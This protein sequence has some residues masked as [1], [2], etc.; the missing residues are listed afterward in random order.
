[1]QFGKGEFLIQ[2]EPKAK[3]YYLFEIFI[4]ILAIIGA[5]Y[6]TRF[7][8]QIIPSM[9]LNE[10]TSVLMKMSSI[11]LLI[12]FPIA[13]IIFWLESKGSFI[14]TN[15]R[16]IIEGRKSS[17]TSEITLLNVERI[18]LTTSLVEIFTFCQSLSVFLKD[19]DSP[20]VQIGPILR[21][22]AGQLHAILLQ[23]LSG[24][25]VK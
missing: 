6:L 13:A 16:I 22:Q 8:P 2:Q 9:M 5:I 20:P 19:D 23:N 18:E 12:C 14:F 15:K 21:S 11:I 24:P 25:L 17:Q 3:Q 4:V 10:R 1:M 7:W